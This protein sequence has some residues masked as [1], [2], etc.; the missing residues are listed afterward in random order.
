MNVGCWCFTGDV[1]LL[2]SVVAFT[3]NNV[4]KFKFISIIEM[5]ASSISMQ[6]C[7]WLE[8]TTKLCP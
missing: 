2:Y 8:H 6:P 5:T 1:V 7:R 4:T 3:H